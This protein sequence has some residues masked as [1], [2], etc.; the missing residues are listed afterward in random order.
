[1]IDKLWKEGHG[2]SPQCARTHLEGLDEAQRLVDGAAHGQ[3]VHRD[4]LKN[5]VGVDEEEPA[6]RDADLLEE[7]A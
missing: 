7:H 5:A 3:V 1:M 2:C 4:L 6:Q